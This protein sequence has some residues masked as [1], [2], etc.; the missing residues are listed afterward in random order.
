[1]WI[2]FPTIARHE[3]EYCLAHF[4]ARNSQVSLHLLIMILLQRI[5]PICLLLVAIASCPAIAQIWPRASGAVSEVMLFAD[6][7]K[8]WVSPWAV[9]P[10][11]YPA[12][13][14]AANATGH[15][16]VEVSVDMGGNVTNARIVGSTPENKAF[17]MAVSQTIKIWMF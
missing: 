6:D 4:C 16:D 17:E 12:E 5:S 9:V 11:E 15:V 13:Q 2:L 7:P 14:L 1:M 3:N 10:P 8:T